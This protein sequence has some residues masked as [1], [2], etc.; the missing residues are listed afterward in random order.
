MCGFIGFA[1]TTLRFNKE[2][3]INDMMD[4][5]VH[6]GPDSAGVYSD[7][8]VTLGFRR[9]KIIDL[10]EDASQPMYNED[11]TCV[12]IFN[13]E[14]YNFQELRKELE[15]KGHIFKSHTDSEVLIH[16]YEEYG[17]EL[18]KKLR[19][20]FAFAIWDT[21][22][23]SLFI[24]RDFF[25]IKPLYYT[26][27]TEDNSFIFGSEIKSFLKHP[28][29]KKELNKDA[30]K[31]YLT[32]Q[33]SV[34]EETF[35]KGVYKLKPGHYMIYKDGQIETKQYWDPKFD[36]KENSLEY[37]VEK[38]KETMKESVAYHQISDVKVGSFLSGG[39]DSSYITSLLMPN[40]TFSVGF[41]V[42]EAIFDE[43]DMAKDLS[44][45]LNIQNERKIIS[46]DECF[47]MLPTIQY[48]MDEPQ[49]NPSS[50]PLYF[51]AGLA[52]EH[53]TV[54]LSGEGADEIFG[55]YPWYQQSPSMEKY[56]KVPFAFRRSISNVAKMLPRNKITNFLIK[57]GQRVEE[58]FI[59]EAKVFEEEDAYKVL[60]EEYRKGPSVGSVTKK[61]YDKVKNKDD[62]TK[63]QYLDLNLWLPGD[64]LLKA[65]KMSMAHSLELRVPFLD[66]EVMALASKLPSEIRVNNIDT[67][68]ALRV[69]ANETLPDEWAK[70]PKLGFPVPIRYW[71]REKKYYDL[72]KEMFQSDMAK[73]FFNTDE[74][75]RYLDEHYTKKS[76]YA[77]YIWTV[78]VFLVWY[79]KFFI[80]M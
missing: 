77:R 51:L 35:F 17:V 65:D 59:G 3:V 15:E 58:K 12:L 76:N 38:I 41:E 52:R 25:G 75:I 29:F 39:V 33:Y 50:V 22:N 1:N 46:A 37:Y 27:N 67:K 73:E 57:G 74:L 63:M 47:E 78:Y 64:I 72:I 68:Y 6:R 13:G 30:L 16:G 10:S 61:V 26:Q 2:T 54:V 66:K 28:G 53:V 21:K 55:G 56:E 80:E 24:A 20:M 18:L 23:E 36:E 8:K 7:D 4:M 62:V 34:L 44:D 60:K 79:Q 45:I 49:S 11:K 31:P 32:F 70:R 14:I 5:I 42:Y 69:A 40:K 19:G 43:T 9:L 71:M 48:H